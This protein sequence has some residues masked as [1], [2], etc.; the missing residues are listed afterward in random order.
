MRQTEGTAP[1]LDILP[2]NYRNLLD[3][4]TILRFLTPVTRLNHLPMVIR[5]NILEEL[6]HNCS[7]ESNW[8]LKGGKQR[9]L[10]II[11]PTHQV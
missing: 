11:C 3:K 5:L 6:Y 4:A 10:S 7:M 8:P 1:S 2:D 9:F